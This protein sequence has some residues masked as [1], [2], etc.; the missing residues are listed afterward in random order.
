MPFYYSGHAITWLELVGPLLGLLYAFLLLNSSSP[1]SSLGWYSCSFRH[2]HPIPILHSH[3]LLLSLLGIPNVNYHILYIRGLWAFPPTPYLLNSL[4]W[5]SL[6]H[7]CLLSI[8]HNAHGFTT[9]F[10]RLLWARLLSLRPF[11]YLFRSMVHYSC[12][13][14]LIVFFSIY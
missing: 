11:C 13:S 1:V 5:A 7:S 8:S 10:S 12:H 6:A 14:G 2:P 4:L 9:S 3:V